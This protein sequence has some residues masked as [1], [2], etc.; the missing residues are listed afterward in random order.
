MFRNDWYCC[1]N[2]GR[3]GVTRVGEQRKIL[4]LF[5]DPEGWRPLGIP[6]RRLE[7]NI[8]MY[9]HEIELEGM[10]WINL[11]QDRGSWQAAVNKVMNFAV[12]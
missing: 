4:R 10:D 11:A 9:L 6:R 12:P 8:N 2:G 5:G 3:N 1:C 7:I